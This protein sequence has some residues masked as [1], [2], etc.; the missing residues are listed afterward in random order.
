MYSMTE[1][2]VEFAVKGLLIKYVPD[3][4]IKKALAELDNW[5]GNAMASDNE[6]L[7]IELGA[8]GY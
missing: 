2:E 8:R 1:E 7:T 3:A 6:K 5:L 4:N